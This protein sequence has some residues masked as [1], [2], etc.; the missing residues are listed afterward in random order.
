MNDN[1]LNPYWSDVKAQLQNARLIAWDTCHKIYIAMDEGQER[2]YRENYTIT[3]SDFIGGQ[4][5]AGVFVGTP[6][7]MLAKLHE[8][9]NASCGLRFISAVW[10]DDED[11]NNGFVTLVPQFA[12]AESV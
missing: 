10:T 1:L 8:W 12:D 7:E 3:G 5:D 11:Q 2:W 6:D 9:W 4:S